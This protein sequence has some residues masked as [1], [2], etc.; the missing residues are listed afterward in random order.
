MARMY[1]RR[2]GISGSTKPSVK[3]KKAWVKYDSKE[4]ESLIVKLVKS[5]MSKSEIGLTLRD[6]YGVPSVK[7]ITKKSI[8][9]IIE[10]NKLE[11]ELPEDLSAL[12]MRDIQIIKH[13]ENN[14]QDMVAKRGLQLT[15][16]KIN[17]LIR[18]YKKTKKLP[19][20]WKYDKDKARL[21]VG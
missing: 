4:I 9:K 7:D 21:L 17:R 15:E 14:K 6:S 5:G 8:G 12:I 18:Y 10:K 11:Q 13:L 2:K 20:D 16:S 19:Q 1:S 3:K